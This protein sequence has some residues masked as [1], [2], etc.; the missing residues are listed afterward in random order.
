MYSKLLTLIALLSSIRFS[1]QEMPYQ[2]GPL[3]EGTKFEYSGKVD[4]FEKSE[5]ILYNAIINESSSVISIST[6]GLPNVILIPKNSYGGGE[7]YRKLKDGNYVRII[8][9][10]KNGDKLG[11]YKIDTD[12]ISTKV[13]DI[14]TTDDIAGALIIGYRLYWSNL[15]SEIFGRDEPHSFKEI[16]RLKVPTLDYDISLDEKMSELDLHFLFLEK[17]DNVVGV[18]ADANQKIGSLQEYSNYINEKNI[19]NMKKYGLELKSS[20]LKK[21]MFKGFD[22]VVETFLGKHANGETIDAKSITFK[23]DRFFYSIFYV[24]NSETEELI[25]GIEIITE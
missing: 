2:M 14:D 1:G 6:E 9:C 24:A 23:I 5:T 25:N 16:Q 22:S 18:T 8:E 4:L 19:R 7:L 20:N 12:N 3:P 21:D 17:E 11:L 13:M 15:N 10:R